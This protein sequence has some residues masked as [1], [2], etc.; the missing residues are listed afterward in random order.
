MKTTNSLIIEQHGKQTTIYSKRVIEKVYGELAAFCRTYNNSR[1]SETPTNIIK[2]NLAMFKAMT[3]KDNGQWHREQIATINDSHSTQSKFGKFINHHT[4]N[5]RKEQIKAIG[6]LLAIY[7]DARHIKPYYY[8]SGIFSYKHEHLTDQLNPFSND[9]NK[10]QIKDK[11]SVIKVI[12]EHESISLKTDVWERIK[13]YFHIVNFTDEIGINDILSI[14]NKIIQIINDSKISTDLNRWTPQQIFAIIK[15]VDKVKKETYRNAINDYAKSIGVESAEKL[16]ENV[17]PYQDDRIYK[18]IKEEL[19]ALFDV[20][21]KVHGI[22]RKYK[23]G[24]SRNLTHY[25]DPTPFIYNDSTLTINEQTNEITINEKEREKALKDF[26]N[27]YEFTDNDH[28]SE[29]RKENIERE[30]SKE[31]GNGHTTNEIWQILN[32][33]PIG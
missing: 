6:E 28:I 5:K 31:I 23:I 13:E 19:K 22:G 14:Q 25:G 9:G 1:A 3:E 11:E 15:D 26:F 33:E 17:P 7:Y 2:Y 10:L 4:D 20:M 16:I 8:D 29:A 32:N 18:G 12:K 24:Y 30:L 27:M 21:D